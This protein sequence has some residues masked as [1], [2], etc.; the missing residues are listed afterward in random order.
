[1]MD[2][3][4][5]EQISLPQLAIPMA[6]T[7]LIGYCLDLHPAISLACGAFV[8]I[9][10]SLVT[11]LSRH[12]TGLH[13][14]N[15]LSP[16]DLADTKQLIVFDRFYEAA[17]KDNYHKE[18]L[19]LLIRLHPILKEMYLHLVRNERELINFDK[20]SNRL[21]SATGSDCMRSTRTFFDYLLSQ[22]ECIHAGLESS[23]K[24]FYM[25]RNIVTST[26]MSVDNPLPKLFRTIHTWVPA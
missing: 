2:I 5:R 25:D 17:M 7:M 4:A 8:S 1:M 21:K 9:V 26:A 20:Y 15:Q 11:V 19:T 14:V 12:Y 13:P 24:D 16:N 3:I 23:F 10:Y 22:L 6:V 18:E